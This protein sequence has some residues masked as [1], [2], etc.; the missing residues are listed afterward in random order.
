MSGDRNMYASGSGDGQRS[1]WRKRT[2]MELARDCGINFHQAG[3]PEIERF[4]A[5]V[6]EEALAQ[7][8]EPAPIQQNWKSD[9]QKVR[10]ALEPEDWCGDERMIDV[11]DRALTKKPCCLNMAAGTSCLADPRPNCPLLATPPQTEP[12]DSMGMP[13]SCGKPLCSPG[14]HHSLCKLAEQPAHSEQDTVQ[15]L[16]AVVRAQQITI[17]KLEAQRAEQEPV[18]NV[19][20]MRQVLSVAIA[21]LY[22]NYKDDVL[23]VFTLDELQAVVDLSESL[24]PQQVENIYK[25]AW[26]MLAEQPEQEPFQ[27]DWANFEEGR[28]VGRAEALEDGQKPVGKWIGKKVEWTDNPYKFSQGQPIYTSPPPQ[29]KPLTIAEVEQILG[30]HNYEIH[31]D[32]ARYIVRMTEAAHG[33]KGKA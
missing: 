21:G 6:R 5:L 3:W 12:T 13:T 31:G 9:V 7:P 28:K 20:F 17:D 1:G 15:R 16:S 32:R 10:D 33:I 8:E 11:L 18:K 2:I 29:R 22:E 23:R 24:R 30:Q 27:P 19:Q 25:R 26:D 14:N 4:A